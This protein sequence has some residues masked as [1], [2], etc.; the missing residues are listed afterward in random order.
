MGICISVFRIPN[1]VHP[2]ASVSNLYKGNNYSECSDLV[3]TSCVLLAVSLIESLACCREWWV[4]PPLCRPWSAMTCS[5]S[6]E[7][8]SSSGLS[9]RIKTRSKR[10]RRAL[11]ILK[12]RKC[13]SYTPVHVFPMVW[14]PDSTL[15]RPVSGALSIQDNTIPK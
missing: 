8:I 11:F 2:L 6:M 5:E 14:Y 3:P 10:D 12:N 4:W 13:G 9:R 15:S 7:S 1:P